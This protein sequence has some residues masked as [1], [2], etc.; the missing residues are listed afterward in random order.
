MQQGVDAKDDN[1]AAAG[2]STGTTA[3]MP[4]SVSWDLSNALLDEAT[5]VAAAQA[6]PAGVTVGNSSGSLLGHEEPSIY[7]EQTMSTADTGQHWQGVLQL[8][9]V[10][11]DSM[12]PPEGAAGEWHQRTT[13]QQLLAAHQ[14]AAAAAGGAAAGQCPF[15]HGR[16]AAA[17]AAAAAGAAAS[18]SASGSSVSLN[19]VS[20]H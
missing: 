18:A 13:M 8:Q 3:S 19:G 17:A 10:S 5:A 2:P 12:M 6:A 11:F 20:N 1:G 16:A 7:L 14:G 4:R 15:G 9:E